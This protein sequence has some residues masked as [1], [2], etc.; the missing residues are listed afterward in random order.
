MKVSNDTL[1]GSETS[2]MCMKTNKKQLKKRSNMQVNGEACLK[3]M[4]GED[5]KRGDI[6]NKYIQMERCRDYVKYPA[7]LVRIFYSQE[8]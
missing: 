3:I 7:C 8:S 1:D 5:K 6:Q 4:I 2:N